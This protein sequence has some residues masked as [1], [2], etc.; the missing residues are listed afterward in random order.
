MRT[1]FLIAALAL[2]VGVAPAVAQPKERRDRIPAPTLSDKSFMTLFKP[3]LEKAARSV[4]RVQVDG[5]DAALGTVV[6]EDGYVL[7]KASELK[8]GKVTIR[9]PDDRDMDATITATS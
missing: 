4:V 3:T 6:S 9:T 5:R 8:L 2:A 7:T 1:R